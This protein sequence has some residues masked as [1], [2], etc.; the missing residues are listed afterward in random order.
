MSVLRGDLFKDYPLARHTSWRVGGI[1]D[2]CYRP[3]DLDDLCVFLQR[4][5][6]HEHLT[7]L[8]LGSN[9][10]L[11]D[12]GVAGTVVF[13]L[14]RLNRIEL[15]MDGTLY[16]E[17]GVTCAKLA[18]FCVQ[19]GFAEGAFFA[20]IPGT[21]GGALAM[22]AGAFGGETWQ[23]V[24]AVNTLNR[25]GIL[26]QRSVDSFSV[27]YREVSGLDAEFFAS[28]LFH[29]PQGDSDVAQQH[30]K[31]LLKKRNYSQPIGSY[32]CGSVFR[33]PAGDYAARLIDQAGLKG[34][35]LGGA[36]VS[37]KHANFIL[38][39]GG[40]TAL[41]LETLMN[42]VKSRVYEAFGVTLVPEVRILG[43]EKRI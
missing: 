20:G 24:M 16:V 37:E 36:C 35:R 5:P 23:Y 15:L 14:N 4:L 1:A 32:S 22:N 29:F 39:E 11:R 30:L 7:F 8:G 42:R 18:K 12:G 19:Q 31:D 40:A 6:E 34:H 17:A 25:H 10:L 9:V 2:T 41:E 26:S 21:V 13:T 27:G 28:A 43:V 3:C 33:N 38:N